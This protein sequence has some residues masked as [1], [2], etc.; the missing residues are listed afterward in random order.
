MNK[1]FATLIFV[2]TGA[3]LMSAYVPEPAQSMETAHAANGASCV[4]QGETGFFFRSEP[5]PGLR[6]ALL[7][8]DRFAPRFPKSRDS[9]LWER[10]YN[11][12]AQG[13]CA[14][15]DQKTPARRDTWPD[16][17]RRDTGTAPQ[18]THST[19]RAKS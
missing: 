8:V 13:P 2:A 7:V 18:V 9:T 4:W 5:A 6:H 19:M 11:L 15:N 3:L 12:N 16:W 10:N 1:I 17:V 14:S